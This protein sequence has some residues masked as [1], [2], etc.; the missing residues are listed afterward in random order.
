MQPVVVNVPPCALQM[1][2]SSWPLSTTVGHALTCHGPTVG[3]QH[4]LPPPDCLHCEP[5]RACATKESESRNAAP[6]ARRGLP[7]IPPLD[8]LPVTANRYFQGRRWGA[9][10]L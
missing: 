2:A 9:S 6:A 10:I 5:S 1:A 8:V 4:S 3:D 7:M